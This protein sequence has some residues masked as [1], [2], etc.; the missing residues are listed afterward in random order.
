[1]LANSSFRP[2]P[3]FHHL[4]HSCRH[5]TCIAMVVCPIALA[6]R[7]IIIVRPTLIPC[8]GKKRTDSFF[9]SCSHSDAFFAEKFPLFSNISFRN[10]F[11]INCILN[12]TSIVTKEITHAIRDIV[13]IESVVF[14]IAQNR[15][16]TIIGRH[17]NKTVVIVKNI[18]VGNTFIVTQSVNML[19][20]GDVFCRYNIVFQILSSKSLC[21]ID[22]NWCCKSLSC[23]N[24]EGSD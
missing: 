2:V 14:A 9:H 5:T 11:I 19:Q 13:D 21:R 24:H 16:C 7:S 17:H 23:E 20:V 22:I 8:C 12:L 1:M 18:K 6:S 3:I 15:I 4:A 10:Q